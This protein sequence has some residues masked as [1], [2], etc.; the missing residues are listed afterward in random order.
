MPL[1][2][3][4][5]DANEDAKVLSVLSGN[6]DGVVDLDDLGLKKSYSLSN[7]AQHAVGYNNLMIQVNALIVCL[8]LY[9]DLRCYHTVFRRTTP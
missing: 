9:A 8:E 5:A 7:A 6:W 3:K 2:Q 1:L 4:A